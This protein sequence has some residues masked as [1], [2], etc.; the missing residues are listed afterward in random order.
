MLGQEGRGGGVIR[1]RM[2][3]RVVRVHEDDGVVFFF[4]WGGGCY[5]NLKAILT[6]Q[7]LCDVKRGNKRYIDSTINLNRG[8]S[9]L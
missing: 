6:F 1:G 5:T 7:N 2:V 8:I 9:I 4:F 3:T